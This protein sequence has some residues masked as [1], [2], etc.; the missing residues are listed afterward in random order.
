MRPKAIIASLVALACV[1]CGMSD[2]EVREKTGDAAVTVKH[3]AESASDTLKKAYDDAAAKSKEAM[4]DAGA[5]LS[6]ET[7]KAKVNA[8]FGLISGLD[9][10]GI[11]VD[12]RD[13]KVYLSGTVPSQLDKMKAEGVAYGV[14]GDSS[15]FESTIEVR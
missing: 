6:D 14:V 5:K 7:L 4:K 9:A 2:K 3:A 11:A 1:G 13:G 12:V 8:G 15:K 10:K